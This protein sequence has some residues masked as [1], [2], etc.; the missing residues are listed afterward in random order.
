MRRALRKP[1]ALKLAAPAADVPIRC[2][3]AAL[4]E[5]IVRI[6]SRHVPSAA[7]WPPFGGVM[8]HPECGR[9]WPRGRVWSTVDGRLNGLVVALDAR[10]RSE[11][12]PGIVEA[13]PTYRSLL[14]LFDPIPFGRRELI[15]KL[16]M[17]CAD[18]RHA[19][20]RRR[21]SGRRLLRLAS[22]EPDG[23]SL[24]GPVGRTCRRF[25]HCVRRHRTWQYPGIGL[26]IFLLADRQSTGGYPKNVAVVSYDIRR[27]AQR[28]P[29][30][31]VRFIAV[32]PD[33][34]EEIAKADQATFHR[35]R[36]LMRN[37]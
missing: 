33:E 13:V 12:S 30:D 36:G 7:L 24:G 31:V 27:L 18:R 8:P 9:P 11:A 16:E 32:S 14:V 26:P 1:C 19:K 6:K 25:Q 23:L 20:G 22:L 17:M 28:R 4:I 10:L 5:V 15:A 29:Q 21:F 35:R 2:N 37:V 34:A 3:R